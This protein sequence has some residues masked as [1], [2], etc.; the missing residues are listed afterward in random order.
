MHNPVNVTT[1]VVVTTNTTPVAGNFQAI[2]C[3]TATTFS[4]LA[5]ENDSGQA[6][7]GWEIPA[8]TWLFGQFTGYTLLSG[9]VR[10]HS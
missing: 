3:V 6:M 10:A 2:Q 1:G 5:E 7:T 9:N 4:A 8:G